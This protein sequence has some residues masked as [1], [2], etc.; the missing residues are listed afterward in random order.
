MTDEL[1]SKVKSFRTA[2]SVVKEMLNS[3]IISEDDY[4]EIE[5]IMAEK[6]GLFL[7]TIYR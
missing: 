5:T 2:M 6:Q 7:S 4:A 1:K 3:G